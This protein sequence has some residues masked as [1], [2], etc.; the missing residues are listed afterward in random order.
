MKKKCLVCRQVKLIKEFSY[1][2]ERGNFRSECKECRGE[3]S[4][5]WFKN[6]PGYQKKW[7]KNNPVK[8][9]QYQE[10]HKEKQAIYYRRWYVRHGRKRSKQDRELI[11]LWRKL[12]PE[13]CKTYYLIWYA[14]KVGKI[15]KPKYCSKCGEKRKLVA[16]HDDYKL[17]F[18][19]RW[20][21][22]SCH[23]K[24]HNKKNKEEK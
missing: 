6:H 8:L 24:E 5:K 1:R 4:K 9:R 16:H 11:N 22:Y 14:V 12:N 17:P 3:I 10:K 18:K 19:I 21:C 2:K 23:K 15:K 7:R 13:K 20:L